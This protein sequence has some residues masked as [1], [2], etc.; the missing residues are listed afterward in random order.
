MISLS[1]RQPK[2]VRQEESMSRVEEKEQELVEDDDEDYAEARLIRM[3]EQLVD[4]SI[5]VVQ[6]LVTAN[7]QEIILA[8]NYRLESFFAYQIGIK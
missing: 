8:M 1:P 2:R 3:E 5:Q 7:V 6:E 4:L